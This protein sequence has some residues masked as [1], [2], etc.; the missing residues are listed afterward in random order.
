M[1]NKKRERCCSKRSCSFM[2]LVLLLVMTS[3]SVSTTQHE[4][5]C[6]HDP[7]DFF[8][9]LSVFSSF[10]YFFSVK[11]VTASKLWGD[12]QL[13]EV[14]VSFGEIFARLSTVSGDFDESED[15]KSSKTT[16]VRIFFGFSHLH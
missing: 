8:E 4:L 3:S 13:Y 9:C 2:R 12:T 14:S 1:S 15:T 5:I 11:L 10:M 7:N 16:K 6:Q